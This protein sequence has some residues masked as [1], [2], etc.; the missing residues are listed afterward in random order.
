MKYID[1]IDIIINIKYYFL[2][3]FKIIIYIFP[4]I[5]TEKNNIIDNSK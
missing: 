4:K 5:N 2:F 1:I 3:I